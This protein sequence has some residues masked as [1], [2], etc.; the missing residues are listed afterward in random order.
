MKSFFHNLVA[1]KTITQQNHVFK[2]A[3]QTNNANT[4]EV[5][6]SKI[7]KMYKAVYI[8]VHL[9]LNYQLNALT[10]R[11][12]EL[13]KILMETKIPHINVNEDPKGRGSTIAE[14]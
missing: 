7:F 8:T 4:Q 1:K 13:E 6:E 5:F 3:V 2:S 9:D 12:V 10:D 11:C 14:N